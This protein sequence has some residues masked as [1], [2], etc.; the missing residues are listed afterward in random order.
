MAGSR[1]REGVAA[2]GAGAIDAGSAAGGDA[3]CV[4]STAASGCRADASWDDA[5]AN[6][7]VRDCAS[8]GG[9]AAATGGGR[10]ATSGGGAKEVVGSDGVMA[11]ASIVDQVS[12]TA[13]SGAGPVIA[14]EADA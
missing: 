11:G 9:S 7:S 13:C 4:S 14:A 1:H 12:R 10:Y 5:A 2:R 6:G 8:A 3:S